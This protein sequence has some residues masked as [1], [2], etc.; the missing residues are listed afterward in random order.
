MP[1]PSF[2]ERIAGQ[3]TEIAR[4]HGVV[5]LY[6]CESGSRGWGFASRDS[7]YDVRFIY[8]HPR[9]WY[10]PAANFRLPPAY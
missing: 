8:H 2:A 7:D 6:A 1:E 9:D 10:L 5:I 4:R 3:L